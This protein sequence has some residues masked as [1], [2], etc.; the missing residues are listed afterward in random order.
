[1]I[2]QHQVSNIDCPAEP[3]AGMLDA[4]A[5]VFW[6]LHMHLQL[7]KNLERIHNGAC[8]I[9]QLCIISRL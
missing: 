5:E 4:D 1:M 3:E 9:L 7:I 6:A 8:A 2:A